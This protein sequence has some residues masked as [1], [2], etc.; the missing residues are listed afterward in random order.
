MQHTRVLCGLKFCVRTRAAKF[1]PARTHKSLR[2]FARTRTLLTRTRPTPQTIPT[3]ARPA[4]H[5]SG[6]KPAP[7]RKLLK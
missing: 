2:N 7:V 4:T 3:R 1:T 6:L 5:F